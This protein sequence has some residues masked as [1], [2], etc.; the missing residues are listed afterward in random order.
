MVGC[1]KGFASLEQKENQNLVRTHCFLHREVLVSKVSQENLKQ[2][3][4]QIVEIVNYIKSRPIKSRLFE[5]LCKSMDSQQ[6][7]LLMHTDV[8][9]LSKG[10]VLT[11]VHELQKELILFFYK[12]KHE[13]FCKYLRYEFWLAKMEYLTEIFGQINIVNSS[14][15]GRNENIITSTDKLVALKKKIVIW[16]NIAKLG[17]FD[18]LPTM[19]TNCTKEMIPILV[20]HLTAIEENIDHYFPSLNTEMYDWVRNHF[21][22]VPSN[23]GFK[24]CEEEELATISSDRSHKVE[25][26]AVD[27]DTFWISIQKRNFPH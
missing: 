26:S 10:K 2:V 13:R 17:E 15:Q 22:D 14:M 7:R 16:K 23:I 9:W 25:H 4:H 8:R 24:L 12:E 11:R 1:I 27:I 21:V 5:E 6:F 3:L 20:E 18:M 19:R